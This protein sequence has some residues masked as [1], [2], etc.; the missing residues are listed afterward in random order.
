[1]L[2]S[3]LTRCRV[4]ALLIAFGLGLITQ[5]VSDA[6]TASQMQAP[7]QSILGTD[8][9]SRTCLA[10]AGTGVMVECIVG[11]CWTIPGLP[12]QSAMIERQ[13]AAGFR[14]AVESNVAGMP[15]A[16]DPYP[17]RLLHYA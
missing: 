9:S 3:F 1:M 11:A 4:V 10:A 12:A 5:G 14:E 13:S 16:P 2:G 17:P 6:A 7:N 15:P 8:H